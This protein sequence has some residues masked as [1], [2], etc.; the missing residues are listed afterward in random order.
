MRGWFRRSH[1]IIFYRA[2][3]T[4][5]PSSGTIFMPS[6]DLAR[7]P[8]LVCELHFTGS[9]QNKHSGPTLKVVLHDWGIHRGLTSHLIIVYFLSPAVGL[10]IENRTAE[11]VGHLRSMRSSPTAWP[12]ETRCLICSLHQVYYRTY[13][14]LK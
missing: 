13:R 1:R 11:P 10:A 2:L 14:R 12:V 5:L 3:S 4:A 9:L 7:I 6:I 8:K